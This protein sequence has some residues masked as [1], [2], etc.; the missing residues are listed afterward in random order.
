MLAYITFDRIHTI[1]V[2]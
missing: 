2:A 1:Q